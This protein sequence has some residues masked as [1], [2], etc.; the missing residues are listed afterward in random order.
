MELGIIGDGEILIEINTLDM[1]G[2]LLDIHAKPM[3]RLLQAD[4][5]NKAFRCC[6]EY[7]IRCVS[8][9]DNCNKILIRGVRINIYTPSLNKS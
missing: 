3:P 5:G 4:I 6:A 7:S 1:Q 9:N 2:T 8:F